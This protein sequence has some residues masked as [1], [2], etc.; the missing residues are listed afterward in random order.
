MADA[1]DQ[2][3]ASELRRLGH[4]DYSTAVGYKLNAIL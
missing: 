2:F 1:L 3:V 4:P